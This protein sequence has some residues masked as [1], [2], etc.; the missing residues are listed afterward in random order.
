[1]MTRRGFFATLY[2]TRTMLY[3]EWGIILY[4]SDDPGT[5]YWQVTA[6]RSEAGRQVLISWDETFLLLRR[7]ARARIWSRCSIPMPEYIR[8]QVEY[9]TVAG[10]VR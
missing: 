1:M 6:P 3:P 10:S 8:R 5:V 4:P 7:C 9:F 2:A